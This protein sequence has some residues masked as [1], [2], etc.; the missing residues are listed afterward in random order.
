MNQSTFQMISI[1]IIGSLQCIQ[2]IQGEINIERDNIDESPTLFGAH[3]KQNQKLEI[4]N[5][6]KSSVGL[7]VKFIWGFTIANQL[8]GR[9]SR[10]V[11][12]NETTKQRAKAQEKLN[13][14][15]KKRQKKNE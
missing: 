12:Q 14:V 2:V 15:K 3:I 6:S 10:A 5:S 11:N 7:I 13:I 8:F 4:K 9:L 1:E